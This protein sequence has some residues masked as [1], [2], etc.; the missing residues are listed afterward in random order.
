MIGLRGRTED[1]LRG[2]LLDLGST[3]SQV[4]LKHDGGFDYDA[5]ASAISPSTRLIHVQR[6]CG[7][8]WRPSI[9]VSQIGELT[10]WLKKRWPDLVLFVDNCYGEFVE[11]IEP[12]AVGADLIAGSLIKNPGGTIAL[13]GGY[14][15]GR[16]DLVAAAACR[17]SSPGVEGGATLGQN[18][19]MFQ[20]LFHAPQVRQFVPEVLE[21][22]CICASPRP[23]DVFDWASRPSL[24]AGLIHRARF[25]PKDNISQVVL[26]LSS[27]ASD[28][29]QPID[30][31][32]YL[33]FSPVC[34]CRWSVRLSKGL[35]SWRT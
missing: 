32:N 8:S 5:I 9:P 34:I 25:H 2:T 21:H 18:R 24:C 6:S 7:Y 16:A 12:C 26:P 19:A 3:Y 11:E 35:I 14:V 13:T 30:G 29:D 17:L 22:C 28:V 10:S 27:L 1:K 4:D 33:L 31:S 23:L 20:G 15:A